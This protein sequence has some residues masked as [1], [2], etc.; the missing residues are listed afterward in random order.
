MSYVYHHVSVTRIVDGDTVRLSINMGN[1][2]TWEDNFRL[3][4]IDAPDRD[5]VKKNE[6]TQHL[7]NLLANG[8]H[9]IETFKPDKFGRWL[10]AIYIGIAGGGHMCVNTLM[11]TSGHAIAYFGGKKTQ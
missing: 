5:K 4:G 8:I 10:V 7:T 3:N 11:I 2:I 1:K 6:A 9:H